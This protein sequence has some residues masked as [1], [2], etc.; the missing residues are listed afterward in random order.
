MRLP[1]RWKW[2]PP[3]ARHALGSAVTST[4]PSKSLLPERV[5]ALITPPVER[6]N[7]TE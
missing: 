2:S 1:S 4:P 7:S 5:T 6:P 3:L